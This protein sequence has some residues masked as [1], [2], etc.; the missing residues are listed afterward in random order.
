MTLELKNDNQQYHN[1]EQD[2]A[3]NDDSQ[4][5][6]NNESFKINPLSQD[7][8]TS[9][10]IF[11]NQNNTSRFKVQKNY[12]VK[13]IFENLEQTSKVKVQIGFNS[14]FKKIELVRIYT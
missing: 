6:V 7:P 13:N 12:K 8:K 10:P 1:N 2:D 11:F 14:S 5:L 9:L 4:R 3:I